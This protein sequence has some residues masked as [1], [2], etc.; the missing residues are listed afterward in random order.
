MDYCI[1]GR[2]T[3]TGRLGLAVASYSL[4][5]GR[6]CDG[7]V[8]PG[9]GATFTVGNAHPRNNRL[10]LGLLAQGFA[11]QAVLESLASNDPHHEWRQ[12]GVLDREGAVQVH[13]GHRMHATAQRTGEGWAAYGNGLANTSIA[14]AMAAAFTE[15][16]SS[17]LD[18]R[19]LAALEAGRAAGGL[20]GRDGRLPARS[21]ALV[22]W[23]LRDFNEIDLRVDLHPDAVA[24]LRR[25]YDDTKPTL[26]Y[27]DERGRSPHNAE[28]PIAFAE[29][30]RR[31]QGK[32]TA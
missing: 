4:A 22:S 27:Y 11:V 12:V 25:L 32:E 28:S 17:D 24:E 10:A 29:R 8:R 18:L 9:T 6:Y 2:C 23:H 20:S 19:L 13:T 15:R 14:N 31:Q 16:P 21:A 3:R 1:L 5:I 30:L 26:A 7:S